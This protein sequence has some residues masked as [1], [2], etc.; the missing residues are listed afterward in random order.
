MTDQRIQWFP[1]HMNKAGKQMREVF[2]RVDVFIELLDGRIPASSA[3][4]MLARLRGDKPCLRVMTKTDL[5]DRQL[6]RIWQEFYQSRPTVRVLPAD[7]K[8]GRSVAQVAGLCRELY[9]AHGG[10][11]ERITA[12]VTGIPNVGKST[13]INRLAGRVVAKTGNQPALTRQQQWIEIQPRFVLL[14]TPGLMWPNVESCNAGYRLAVT[15]AIGD[16]AISHVEVALFALRYLRQNYASKL[17][18]RYKPGAIKAMT[19]QEILTAAGWRR[20]CLMAG[21]KVDLDRAAKMVI[22]DIRD[23]RLGRITW[24]T[25]AMVEAERIEVERARPEKARN[26]AGGEARRRADYPDYP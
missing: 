10:C 19:E 18:E 4:P 21:G 11:R 13:L 22:A 6:T 15:G 25:P 12:M 24:E 16:S 23:G 26:K 2:P 7:L 3:N 8:N 1:G 9:V 17:I 5:S 14:D 20:G